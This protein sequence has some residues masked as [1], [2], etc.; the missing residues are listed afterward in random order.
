MKIKTIIIL[1]ILMLTSVFFAGCVG[2]DEPIIDENIPVIDETPEE[3]DETPIEENEVVDNTPAV[4][5]K[6]YTIRME[7]YIVQIPKPFEINR[8]DTIVWNNFQDPKRY[9]TIVSE[10]GL[11]ENTTLGY[12]QTLVYTFNNSGTYNFSVIGQPRMSGSIIVK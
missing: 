11:W 5:P 9:L 4:D 7:Y 6:T 8:G 1:L 2:N 10:D 12:R 3:V